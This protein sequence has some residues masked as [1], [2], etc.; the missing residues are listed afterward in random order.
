MQTIAT[1][2]APAAIGPYSQAIL[3]N[4]MLYT[5]GQIAL[6]P[7]SMEIVPGGV[8]EQTEQVFK[9]L[10]AVLTAAGMTCGGS[11]S[12]R[13]SFAN[14]VRSRVYRRSG[15]SSMA[16]LPFCHG[17][18]RVGFTGSSGTPENRWQVPQALVSST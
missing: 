1:P 16:S 4:G 12:Q 17:V 15:A 5:A 14:V 8:T 6:D 2:D 10:G 9:N 3:V 18:V 7:I 13:V 11:R